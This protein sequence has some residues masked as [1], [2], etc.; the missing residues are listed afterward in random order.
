MAISGSP[1]TTPATARL[2]LRER[3][4]QR[5]STTIGRVTV[6]L[7]TDK[8]F[9]AVRVDD[10]CEAAEVSRSTFFRYFDSKES[11]YTVGFSAWRLEAVLD[12]LGHRPDTEDALTAIRNAVIEQTED[13]REDR[14]LLLFDYELRMSVPA[15]NARALAEFLTW[16]VAIAA[17]IEN[18]LPSSPNRELNARL[19]AALAMTAL[20]IALHQW[21]KA[22]ATEPPGPLYRRSFAAAAELIS[23]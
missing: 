4:K 11:S 21:L 14:V 15:V 2:P 20:G 7:V 16:E 9:D 18:R 23:V 10:I 19:T 22:G 12:A 8:G 3:K 6:D 1:V 13:W 5:T 17:A